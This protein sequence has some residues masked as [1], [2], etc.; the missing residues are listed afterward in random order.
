MARSAA[1][2]Y[3]VC[4]IYWGSES[5]QNARV[6]PYGEDFNSASILYPAA[7][8]PY[9]TATLTKAQGGYL[10]VDSQNLTIVRPG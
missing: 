10:V 8:D 4:E 2:V 6:R 7:S 3:T 5:G 1:S 9:F